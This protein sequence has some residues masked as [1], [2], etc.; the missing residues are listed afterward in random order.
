[1]KGRMDCNNVE[2]RRIEASIKG[3]TIIRVNDGMYS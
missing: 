2:S 3:P 1:M